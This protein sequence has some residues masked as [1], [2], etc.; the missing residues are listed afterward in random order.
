MNFYLDFF[1]HHYTDRNV[2]TESNYN[3]RRPATVIILRIETVI[4]RKKKTISQ[5]IF[6][7][8]KYTLLHLSASC[9]D[10]IAVPHWSSARRVSPL[11]LCA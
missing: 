7:K 8:K 1:V 10:L 6:N 11:K 9:K 5:K 3:T 4:Y 2:Y